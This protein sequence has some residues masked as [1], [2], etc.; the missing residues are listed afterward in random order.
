M[1]GEKMLMSARCVTLNVSFD[2]E[3]YIDA[4]WPTLTVTRF[5]RRSIRAT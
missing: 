3:K 2:G 4:F 1:K 5:S